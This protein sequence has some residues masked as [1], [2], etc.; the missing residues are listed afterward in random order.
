MSPE[1]KKAYHA[2]KQREYAARNKEKIRERAKKYREANKDKIAK[3]FKEWAEKNRPVTRRYKK[4]TDGFG[5]AI[6]R[7]RQRRERYA[8][9]PNYKLR[10]RIHSD[11]WKVTRGV[12][13][14]GK[15]FRLLGCSLDE[16]SA[17]IE[18]QFVEGM[19]FDNLGEWEVDHIQPLHTFD[20]TDPE[21]LAKACH[22]SNLRPLWVKDNRK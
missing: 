10:Q 12:L 17:H 18:A 13:R 6:D 8:S 21:Q 16:L 15:M 14:S 2:M 22:F 3:A 20:L 1:D 9:D 19:S 5:K 4:H 11:M 7:A